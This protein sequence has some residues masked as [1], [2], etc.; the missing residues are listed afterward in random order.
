MSRRALLVAMFL[1]GAGGCAGRLLPLTPVDVMALERER[2]RAAELT[3][4]WAGHPGVMLLAEDL[5]EHEIEQSTGQW[6]LYRVRVR[7]YLVL[8]AGD[9][10]MTTFKQTTGKDWRLRKVELVVLPP[11]GKAKRFGLD[12]L[13]KQAKDKDKTVYKLAYPAVTAGTIIAE[14]TEQQHIDQA[15]DPNIGHTLFINL[16]LPTL[17]RRVAYVHPS[18]WVVLIKRIGRKVGWRTRHVSG[19][20]RMVS[21]ERTDVPPLPDEPFSPHGREDGTY[22]ALTIN[23]FQVNHLS[24]YGPTSWK[25]LAGRFRKYVVDND[26]VFSGRVQ[27]LT[28][29]LVAG[30]QQPQKR[31]EAIVRHVQRNI[32][33]DEE[34]EKKDFAEVLKTGRGSARQ[35]TG[36]THLMLKKAGIQSRYVLI[37][38]AR[39]GHHDSRYLSWATFDL[40]AVSAQVDGKEQLVLPFVKG[41]LPGLLPPFAQGRRAMRIGDKGFEAFFTTPFA[42]S[43]HSRVDELYRVRVDPKGV[44]HIEEERT[45][46]GHAAFSRRRKLEDLK[47]DELQKE[48]RDDLTY[49]DGQVKVRS[50]KVVDLKD[51]EKP[52]KIRYSYTVDN[53]VTLAGDEAVLQTA[54]LFA[55]TSRARKVLQSKRR[56]RPIRV[57]GDVTYHRE[58]VLA[59][60]AAWA[61]EAPLKS[62]A[63]KNRYGELTTR[64]ASSP[65]QVKAEQTLRLRRSQGPAS[66][67]GKLEELL[68]KGAGL[69]V[70]SIVFRVAG[71]GEKK[72]KMVP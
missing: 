61:P 21:V 43:G 10:D 12:D 65:G 36:L 67:I 6:T 69:Q 49:T 18:S 1:V 4:K 40:P 70:P 44:L 25:K 63:V 2:V 31:M 38:S 14:R 15:S 29:K 7:R 42:G 16:P 30:I 27:E 60:P 71:A 55:P 19:G 57:Y 24:Y 50:A 51:A 26:A 52:L 45:Y 11:G 48:L 56:V 17:R 33:Q 64:Y 9:E 28:N 41:L 23:F 47:D 53:L 54:G 22:L 5:L 3:Q 39:R 72:P 58:V 46:R 62:T 34:Y 68:G 66:E 32:K 8:D 59:L 35:I 13:V 37:H 20:R